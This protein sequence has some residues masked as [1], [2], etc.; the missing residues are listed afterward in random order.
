MKDTRFLRRYDVKVN[1]PLADC[2]PY[3]IGG[4]ADFFATA[5]TADDLAAIL[6]SAAKND[7]RTRIIGGLNA[8]IVSDHGI[9]GLT[10]RVAI[11]GIEAVKNRATIGAGEPLGEAV[12]RLA[13]SGYGGLEAFAGTPDSTGGAVA[14]NLEAGGERFGKY[15]ESVGLYSRGRLLEVSAEDLEFEPYH[16][17]VLRTG[18]VVTHVV[19]RVVK[20]AEDEIRTKMLK[21]QAEKLKLRP[22]RGAIAMF[23]NH[24]QQ[25]ASDIL[26]Q[27]ETRGEHEGAVTLSAK[28]PN[29]MMIQPGST[30]KDARTLALRMKHRVSVKC[31]IALQ[32]RIIWLGEW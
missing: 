6:D 19:C 30:A 12:T 32:D 27:V 18:E 10:V 28:D 15:V 5:K 4:N 2:S 29:F 16:S 1:E 11:S 26:R 22:G 14:I 25:S 17:R 31:S 20:R 23:R 13:E 9:R 21:V 24:A 8:S 7:L 3:G